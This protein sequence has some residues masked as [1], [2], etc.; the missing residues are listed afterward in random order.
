MV[1]CSC[2]LTFAEDGVRAIVVAN[3]RM[4]R[5]LQAIGWVRQDD[6]IISAN[7]GARIARSLGLW[8]RIVVG[9]MDSLL[10]RLKHELADHGCE[11]IQHSA[12]KDETDTE[13]AVREALR[14]GASELILV[15]ML[16]GRLDH[17]LANVLLL[18]MPELALVPVHIWDGDTQVWLVRGGHSL[19][20]AGELGDIV[21]LLPLGHDATGIHT[22]GLEYALNG[23]TL[24]LGLARGVSN[25]MTGPSAVV[26][27]SGGLLLL[28]LVT[29]RVATP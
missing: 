12:R 8:P 23:E 22:Q 2:Q 21:T 3:G 19:V 20:V 17:C 16:G 25:V 28:V 4:S 26:S 6:L 9:D 15:G 11:F 13:L 27:L 29:S 10:P 24:H 1:H 14:R 5:G 7:G 18:A